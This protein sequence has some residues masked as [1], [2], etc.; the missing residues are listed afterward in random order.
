MPCCLVNCPSRIKSVKISCFTVPK[1]IALK[2]E[3]EKVLG[4]YYLK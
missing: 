2:S 1:N 4:R 3:W